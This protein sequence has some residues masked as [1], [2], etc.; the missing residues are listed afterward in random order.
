MAAQVGLRIRNQNQILQIDG[1]YQNLELV[2]KTDH[3]IP[4]SSP[5]GDMW[6]GSID[7]AVPA[8]RS[9]VTMA[10]KT[11]VATGVYV[12]KI[13]ASIFRVYRGSLSGS[14]PV[15]FTAY[16]FATPIERQSFGLIGLV[17]R[18]R[19]TGSVVY[20]S[21]YRY[22]RILRFAPVDLYM[23]IDGLAPPSVASFS[24]PGKNVAIMQCV[25]PNGR[26]Q[27]PA[28][29]PQMPI[30]VFG[31]FGGTMR[32]DGGGVAIIEHRAIASAIGPNGQSVASQT[33]GTYMII[34]VTGY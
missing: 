19:L 8:G 29:T 25:R 13:G 12:V 11:T 10:V 31:F 23:P 4:V 3:S 5:T 34:D 24:F 28:G 32:T 22:L 20:N 26:R 30:S 21:N 33:F 27:N 6:G 2:S 9:N 17:V 14:N 7:I 18:S 15:V 1:E 16:I